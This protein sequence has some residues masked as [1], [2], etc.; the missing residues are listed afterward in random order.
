[1]N[2]HIEG[3]GGDK[4]LSNN[5]RSKG[6]VLALYTSFNPHNSLSH[7]TDEVAEVQSVS[8]E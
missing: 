3:N 4:L 5:Y 1:M 8:Q 6:T 2:L 7:F